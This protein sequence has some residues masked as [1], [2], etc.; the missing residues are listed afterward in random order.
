MNAYIIVEGAETELS[1]YPAWLSILAPHLSQI[2]DAWEVSENNYYLFNGGG[3]P[4][5]FKHAAQA[6]ANVNEINAA[7]K[8]KYD[9]VI[10]CCDTENES[11]EYIE[12]RLGEYI[13]KEGVSLNDAELL[14][15]EQKVCMETWFIGNTKVFKS[16]PQGYE[17]IEYLRFYN[18]KQNNPEYMGTI[19]EERFTKAQFHLRY[20]K[21]MLEERNLTY[22]K[23][24]TAVVCT[25]DYLSE[26]I[27]RYEQTQHLSTFGTWYEFV[28]DHLS[29]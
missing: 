5:I 9:Y 12:K 16:N 28:R 11:R 14:I 21:R 4:H 22:N 18:A 3:Q 7:G 8:G 23:N 20:L 29:K 2:N 15:F 25:P 13:E 19:D 10:V 27:R 17:M 6:I 1:V 26:L 24:N